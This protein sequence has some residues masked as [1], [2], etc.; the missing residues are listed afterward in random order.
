V[1]RD[2]MRRITSVTLLA[3]VSISGCTFEPGTG[4][5]TITEAEVAAF[6]EPGAARQLDDGNLLT[7][8]GYHIDVE[9]LSLRVESISL[10]EFRAS[11]G[12]E[13][14]F[15][16]A[17]PPPGYT[18]CHGG[19]CHADDGSLVSYEDVQAEMAGGGSSFTPLATLPVEADLDILDDETILLDE[20]LPSRELPRGTIA[21]VVMSLGSLNLRATVTGGT[22]E[23]DLGDR[24]VDFSADLDISTPITVVTSRSID[25]DSSET[26]ELHVDLIADGTLFDG[27]DIR[28]LADEDDRV[29]FEN[30]DEP[31]A[32]VLTG[33]LLGSDLVV[34]F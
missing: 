10:D 8:L 32:L 12:S 22:N 26:I 15:D 23:Y 11:G 1:R 6:F 29:V 13:G 19:H 9:E 5:A 18:L 28:A 24:E 14:S 16:P 27:L 20:V 25:R 30:M 17:D 4:F 31:A 34:S 2:A 33:S 3:L 21:R 7:D